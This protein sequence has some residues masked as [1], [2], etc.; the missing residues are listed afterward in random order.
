MRG[1]REKLSALNADLESGQI[2]LDDWAEQFY[3]EIKEG[4]AAAAAMGQGRAGQTHV[5]LEEINR[6][7]REKADE[8]SEHLH[9]FRAAIAAMDPRYVDEDGIRPGSLEARTDLYVGK[10]R[11]TANQ[12]VVESSPDTALWTWQLGPEQHCPDCPHY[13]SIIHRVPASEVIAYPGDGNSACLGH[14]GCDLVRDDGVTGFA[15]NGAHMASPKAQ[16]QVLQ[17]VDIESSGMPRL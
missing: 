3:R 11:G 4:H 16:P 6:I 7:A 1:V 14:C 10:M 9:D 5:D 15:N 13:A 12:E 2:S 17:A 8:E